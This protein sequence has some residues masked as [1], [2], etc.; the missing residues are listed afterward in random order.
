MGEFIKTFFFDTYAFFE[1]IHGNPNYDNYKKDIAIIT[2]KL[3]L[4]E[5]HY[6]LL[7][8]FGKEIADYY[9]DFYSKFAVEIPNDIIKL[10]NYFKKVMKNR[11]VSYIDC[12]GYTLAKSRNIL[13]LTGDKQFR[14]LDNVEFVK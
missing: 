3:N 14:D 11:N 1:M 7:L 2:T 13:F 10:A 5:L 12:I 9:F 8:S 6:G 4:M